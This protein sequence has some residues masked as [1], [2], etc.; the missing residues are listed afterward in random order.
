MKI[1][2]V[3]FAASEGGA[4]SVLN[5][6]VDNIKKSQTKHDWYFLLSGAY[7]EETQNIKIINLKKYKNPFRRITFDFFLGSKI[8]N[9][10]KPDVVFNMQN[11][12]VRGVVGPQIIYLHQAIPFQENKKFSFIK[13]NERKYAFIQYGLGT[14]IKRGLKKANKIIVQSHWMKDSL[15]KLSI[16][17]EKIFVFSPSVT[18][19]KNNIVS[20][21]R[22]DQF[23]YPTSD[24]IYKN[25][26]IIDKASSLI[27][28]L[29]FNVEIT[30]TRD[31]TSKKIHSVG[32]LPKSNVFKK[33][34]SKV[35]IFPSVIETFGL[36]LLEARLSNAVIIA[37]DTP[38]AREILKNYNNAYYF[39]SYE[40]TQ[41]ALLMKE[42]I[43]GKIVRKSNEKQN[44][45]LSNTWDLVLETIENV[46]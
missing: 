25:I 9:K 44:N 19:E 38:F 3:N 26:D 30:I 37:A 16:E 2:V 42:C 41:L 45:K 31:L 22:M 35:M 46:D 10:I 28:Y 33:Y 14:M 5:E 11:N 4:L 32:Y 40:E 29:N 17:E 36:P 18:I 7:F 21:Y 1:V 13:S 34:K 43:E 15:L 39:D 27:E 23:F 8:I 6:F 12:F 20:S 24:Y